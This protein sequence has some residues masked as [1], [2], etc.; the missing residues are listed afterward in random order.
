[1]SDDLKT[2]ISK[3]LASLGHTLSDDDLTT[4]AAKLNGRKT[5]IFKLTIENDKKI[6]ITL[7]KTMSGD[8]TA[9]VIPD[10]DYD[11][12]G[13]GGGGASSA[14]QPAPEQA[15]KPEPV[16]NPPV[17]LDNQTEEKPENAP[18]PEPTAPR[19]FPRPK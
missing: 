5:F 11:G 4:I 3:A 9:S 19:K 17:E 13:N 1:M 6:I 7:S 18:E 2:K 14:P 12:G 15:T 10:A 16:P 8:I